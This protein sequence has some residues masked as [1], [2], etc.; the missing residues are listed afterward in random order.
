MPD[1]KT[2]YDIHIITCSDQ[3]IDRIIKRISQCIR[4]DCDPAGT[5]II[6]SFWK[7]VNITKEMSTPRIAY[8]TYAG[9]DVP[10]PSGFFKTGCVC[11]YPDIISMFCKT[12]NSS[13]FKSILG[14]SEIITIIITLEHPVEITT[15]QYI[16]VVKKLP[17]TL[18]EFFWKP[19]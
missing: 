5:A 6:R 18:F 10:V 19:I 3:L 4:W 16:L 2:S 9:N 7:T 15:Q 8:V 17:S 12:T 13:S 1:P 11:I 14:R